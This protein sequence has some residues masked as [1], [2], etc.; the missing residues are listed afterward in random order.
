M[1]VTTDACLFG[2]IVANEIKS[3][4]PDTGNILDIGCGTGLLT[5]MLAQ[6]ITATIDAIEIEKAAAEQATENIIASPWKNHIH[7]FHEDAKQFDFKVK[8]DLIISNPPFYENELTSGNP[9]RNIALHN[10]GLLF[11]ELL[12]VIKNNLKQEGI[13]YLLLPYKRIEEVD[14]LM[15][16]HKLLL[17]KKILIRQSVKHDYFRII[18]SG[19]HRVSELKSEELSIRDE[20]QQYTPEFMR[21]LKDYYL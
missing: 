6:K 5:L 13:F 2:A 19:G 17:T 7:I 11:D 16:K 3:T 9:K 10:A 18:T 21:L 8:Y 20:D 14:K 4:R 15:K 12:R 1:K